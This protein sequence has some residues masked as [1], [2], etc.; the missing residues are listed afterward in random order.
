M[1]KMKKDVE[2]LI[3]SHQADAIELSKKGDKLKSL[4]RVMDSFEEKEV[5]KTDEADE[6]VDVKGNK[7]VAFEDGGSGRAARAVK[8][9]ARHENEA[10]NC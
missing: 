10:Q 5:K 2:E 4:S 1:E 7:R 8:R 3:V 9:A 6:A